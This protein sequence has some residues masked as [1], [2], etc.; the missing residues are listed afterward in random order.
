MTDTQPLPRRRVAVPVLTLV[1]ALGLGACGPGATAASQSGGTAVSTGRGGD[2]GS[3]T[4]SAG[5]FGSG[6]GFPGAAG[7]VADVTGSTAQVQSTTAQTAVTWTRTTRFTSLAPTTA[8]AVRVGVCI[9]ARP[10]FAGRPSATGTGTPTPTPTAT[11]VAPTVAAATIE[12]FPAT[13]GQCVPAGFGGGNRVAPTGS[14]TAT[15]A[16]AGQNGLRGGGR[17]TVGTVTA[18]ESGAFTV[19]PVV[20]RGPNG[21]G[22]TSLAPVTVTWGASTTFTTLQAATASAVRVGACVTAI[23]RADSTG[24]VTAASM[25]VSRP[26]GG[27]CTTGRGFGGR[28]GFGGGPGAGAPAAGVGNGG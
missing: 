14:P 7:L 12:L 24:A 22:G 10:A 15:G 17:G 23:G 13:S 1:A 3:G 11:G 5:G 16:P 20:L 28:G 4:G 21:P 2:S 27:S 8:A 26:V 19:R 6:R 18:V 9:T 25:Q